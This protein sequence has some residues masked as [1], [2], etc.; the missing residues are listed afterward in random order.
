MSLSTILI[1]FSYYLPLD[2]Q[3]YQRSTGNYTGAWWLFLKLCV[4]ANS[5]NA[6]QLKVCIGCR[7]PSRQKMQNKTHKSKSHHILELNSIHVDLTFQWKHQLRNGEFAMMLPLI[8]TILTIPAAPHSQILWYVM[9]RCFS[10][11]QNQW[12]CIFEAY[13]DNHH[14]W[15]W[16]P[17]LQP[18]DNEADI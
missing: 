9:A 14:R 11:I 13:P 10:C 6:P 2:T 12:V 18:Q 4:N 1:P 16:V 7:S 8:L 15:W 17:Q 3:L 5:Q